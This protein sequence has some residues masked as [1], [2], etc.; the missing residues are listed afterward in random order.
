MIV[1]IPI[2][3]KSMESGVC[4]SFGRAPYFL[5][6]NTV[7]K[8]CE[9]LDNAAVA[10]EGGAGIRAAQVIA[11]RGTKAL[12]TPR[13]GEN[14]QELLSKAEVFVYKTIPGTVQDNLAA[15]AEDKLALLK[16]FHPGFHGHGR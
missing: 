10:S 4:P 9:Y 12:L 2:D 5:F 13:C 7:T 3:E 15:F 11:D 8:D 16:E 1:A 14:A 6:Y